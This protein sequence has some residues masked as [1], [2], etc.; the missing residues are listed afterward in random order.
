[1]TAGEVVDEIYGVRQSKLGL[2][3]AYLQNRK[4]I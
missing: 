4:G 3:G 1:M 2:T